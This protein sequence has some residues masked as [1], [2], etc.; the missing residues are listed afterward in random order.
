MQEQLKGISFNFDIYLFFVVVY[1][2]QYFLYDDVRSLYHVS[3]NEMPAHNAVLQ[4]TL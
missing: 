3:I 1:S 2:L 4:N